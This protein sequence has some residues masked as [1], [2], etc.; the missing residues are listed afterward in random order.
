MAGED[1][2]EGATR[3]GRGGSAVGQSVPSATPA[4]ITITIN[5][6]TYVLSFGDD[7]DPW[8][9]N[10]YDVYPWHTL[11]FTLRERLGL[12]GTKPS[13]N[14]GACGA[15]T[16]LID[17]NAALA[18]TTLTAD[19]HNKDVLT[20]E[21]LGTPDRPHP[22]QK[23]FIENNASQCGFC[24]P[25]MIMATKALLDGNSDPTEDEI[26]WGL[27]NNTCRCGNYTFIIRAV[28]AAA[29]KLRSGAG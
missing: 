5:S 22:I 27:A 29:Q 19:C 15:C 3:L 23:A 10:A 16:V 6:R 13:C 12:T 8:D 25:G 17:G 7:I 21:G 18:C 2:I 14:R 20:I 4:S 1:T 26:K 9:V 11:L 24:T 28:K